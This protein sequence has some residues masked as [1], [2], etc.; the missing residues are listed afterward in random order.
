MADDAVDADEGIMA[1]VVQ[2]KD[3]AERYAKRHIKQTGKLRQYLPKQYLA[4]P[5]LH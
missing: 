1:M 2:V 5:S 4:L 3:Q